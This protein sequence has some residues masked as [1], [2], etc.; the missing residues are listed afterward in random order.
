[1]KT[2]RLQIAATE[3]HCAANEHAVHRQE[4]R[5]A[6]MR[7]N[8]S[9]CALFERSLIWDDKPMRLPEC[10]AAEEAGK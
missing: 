5:C 6:K 9:W 3:T 1:M 8:P 7:V 10:I 2:I 4:G